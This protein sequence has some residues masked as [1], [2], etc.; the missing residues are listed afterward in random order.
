M[1]DLL[2]IT[3]DQKRHYFAVINSSALFRNMISKVC[4]PKTSAML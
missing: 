2:M 1:N 4:K 3:E